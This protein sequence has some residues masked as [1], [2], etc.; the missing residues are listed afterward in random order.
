MTLPDIENIIREYG[1]TDM[2]FC[3]LAHIARTS[4]FYWRNGRPVSHCSGKRIRLLLM[5]LV[6][7]ERKPICLI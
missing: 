1:F 7:K 6:R 3:A 5:R 4:L 2:Q